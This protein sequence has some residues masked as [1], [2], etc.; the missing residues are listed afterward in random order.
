MAEPRG[1]AAREEEGQELVGAAE[2]PELRPAE[3]RLLELHL[4]ALQRW[5]ARV[6]HRTVGH[7]ARR[8]QAAGSPGMLLPLFHR[9]RPAT[10]TQAAA[11]ACARAMQTPNRGRCSYWALVSR[12]AGAV[13]PDIAEGDHQGLRAQR[14]PLLA[15]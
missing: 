10:L 9:Q 2:L 13:L 8:P 14:K 3:A 1:L 12:S 15:M 11:A 4:A 7:P 5:E 6:A